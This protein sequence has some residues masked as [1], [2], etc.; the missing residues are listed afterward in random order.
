MVGIRQFNSFEELEPSTQ[1]IMDALICPHYI[2]LVVATLDASIK[3][4]AQKLHS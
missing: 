4:M 3:L 2:F 1:M